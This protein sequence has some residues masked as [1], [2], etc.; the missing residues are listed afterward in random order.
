MIAAIAATFAIVGATEACRT[1]TQVELVVTYDGECSDVDEVAFIIGT[2]PQ[3]AEARI[4]S[5]VFTTST[6]HCEQGSP[7][8]VGSLVVTPNDTRGA[9]RSSSSPRSD[10]T[11]PRANPRRATRAALSPGAR[12]PSSITRR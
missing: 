6:T 5:N 10:S 3:L 9:H 4:E 7:S 1:A 8:T 2:D 12:L 11:P